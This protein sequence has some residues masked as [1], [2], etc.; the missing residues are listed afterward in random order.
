[1]AYPPSAGTLRLASM[2]LSSAATESA[3]ARLNESSDGTD[4][5]PPYNAA[6][7]ETKS[8]TCKI[9]AIAAAGCHSGAPLANLL[10]P[11]LL[12]LHLL[13]RTACGEGEGAQRRLPA[14]PNGSRGFHVDQ[15][16]CRITIKNRVSGNQSDQLAPVSGDRDQS[17]RSLAPDQVR[18][19]AN[20]GAMNGAYAVEPSNRM[21]RE[22]CHDCGRQKS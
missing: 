22:G 21:K 9:L 15:R 2:R 5:T 16:I 19:S 7:C 4:A 17:C 18:L 11:A 1:M 20:R 6:T 10:V 8:A 13:G 12:C 3:R 14:W